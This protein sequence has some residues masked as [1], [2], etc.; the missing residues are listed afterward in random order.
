M[1]TNT[2][3]VFNQKIAGTLFFAL[4]LMGINISPLQAQSDK[5]M[6]DLK[7]LRSDVGIIGLTA[8]FD[9]LNKFDYFKNDTLTSDGSSELEFKIRNVRMMTPRLGVGLQVLTSFFVNDAE[10]QPSFGIGSWGLGPVVRAYPFKT[11][12][13]QPYVQAEALFGNNMGVGDLSET[14]ASKGFSAR[15]SLR[16]GIAYRL[17]NQFGLFIEA[18]SDWGSSRIFKAQA[19][20]LQIN[21][22][23]DVY[24]FN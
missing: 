17:N 3:H 2:L 24:R 19:R 6:G 22:G 15:M 13:L 11:D 5:N 23:F 21:I 8:N 4:F 20:S 16:G 18:G 12:R 10:D 9:F 7:S 14:N 1:M